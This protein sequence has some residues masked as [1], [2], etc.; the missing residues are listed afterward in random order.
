[1][2]HDDLIND[3]LDDALPPQIAGASLSAMQQAAR[4]R[5]ARRRVAQ[6]SLVA[7]MM[8]TLAWVFLPETQIV[9]YAVT[10]APSQS[11][12]PVMQVRQISDS[13]LFATLEEA[14]YGIAITGG[15]NARQLLFVS[16]DGEIYEP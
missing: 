13:E 1:M 3:M 14:G 12:P 5:I 10:V 11:A 2:K 7:A 8:I 6:A 9:Q 15:G 4:R 16:Q